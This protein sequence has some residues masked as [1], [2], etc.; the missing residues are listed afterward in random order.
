MAQRSQTPLVCINKSSRLSQ[1]SASMQPSL[2]MSVLRRQRLRLASASETQILMRTSSHFARRSST[3]MTPSVRSCKSCFPATLTSQMIL[4]TANFSSSNCSCFWMDSM[5]ST[6]P[7]FTMGSQALGKLQMR[8]QSSLTPLKRLG[9]GRLGVSMASTT[10]ESASG[11]ARSANACSQQLR[12][13]ST[14][15]P[16]CCVFTVG[17]F[18]YMSKKAPTTPCVASAGRQSG[19]SATLCSSAQPCSITEISSLLR[20]LCSAALMSARLSAGR[21]ASTSEML[22]SALTQSARV[23]FAL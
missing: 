13:V 11:A 15:R 2:T 21:S 10:K 7:A 16:S 6:S 22:C 12:F 4:A 20:T 5:A 19:L 17:C 14:L 18:L 23:S 8:L 9:S 3:F 1:Y